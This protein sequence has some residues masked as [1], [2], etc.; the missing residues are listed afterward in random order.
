M[1]NW[2][3]QIAFAGL[4]KAEAIAAAIAGAIEKGELKPG[5]KLPPQRD[6]AWK[7]GVAVGT[8]TRGYI[9]ARQR[10]LVAGEVGS[11]TYVREAA[12]ERIGAGISGF[13]PPEPDDK[14]DLTVNAATSA[15]H[16]EAL[17]RTM[18]EIAATQGLEH[19]LRY[20]TWPY[21]RPHQA[22]A[23]AWLKRIGL[24]APAERI[25]LSNGAHQ[26]LATAFAALAAPGEPVLC[27]WLT[28]TGIIDNARLFGHPL[29]GVE[30]DGEGIVPE[31]LDRAAAESGARVVFVQPTIHNPLA[32]T[33][34]EARRRAIVAVAARR[35]LVLVEDDVYG[36]LPPDRPPPI[37]ALAP[38]RTVYLTSA[39]KAIAPGLRAGWIVAP[40]RLL[41]RM[42]ETRYT[43]TGSLPH[44][45]FEVARRWIESGVAD[46][47]TR[48][49]R[50]QAAR[51]Q[52]VAAEILAGAHVDSHPHGFHVF[53]HL[54]EPWRREEFVAAAED[55]GVRVVPASA[56]APGR[57]PPPPHAVRIS[58]SVAPDEPTLRRALEILRDVLVKRGTRGMTV[59]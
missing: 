58:L 43:M 5:A 29:R 42:R 9:L 59:V 21:Q 14:I 52:R 38:E 17:A 46:E 30:M 24:V 25:V 22:A 27:E 31:A 3:P 13:V 15:L 53:L 16:A 19:F 8:V 4:E 26:G 2:T 50:E 23:A 18:A 39:S 32:V 12:S 20:M 36:G 51:R 10:G 7:L 49:L 57:V 1:T 37:A 45:N 33:M 34:G 40:E 11:G 28:Y 48:A 41:Q 55:R 35:D 54:P 44:L 6:L 56:F 47:L